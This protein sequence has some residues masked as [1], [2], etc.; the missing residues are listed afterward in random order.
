MTLHNSDPERLTSGERD[1]VLERVMARH[2][3]SGDALIEILHVAQQLYGYL[4]RPLLK[5]V[6]RRLSL[7]PSRVLGVATFYHLFRSSAPKLHTAT[8][9]IGTACY[10]A[11]GQELIGELRSRTDPAHWTVETGRCMGS[12]GLAPIVV[13]DGVAVPRVRADQMELFLKEANDGGDS[14]SDTSH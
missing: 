5:S 11:G 7:P 13:C 3:Y 2:H 8:V 4:S 1:K 14:K 9:C 12:C 10:V 6:A